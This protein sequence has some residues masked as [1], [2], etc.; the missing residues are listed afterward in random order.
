MLTYQDIKELVEKTIEQGKGLYMMSRDDIFIYLANLVAVEEQIAEFLRNI[1]TEINKV[2][3]D[4][5]RQNP[6]I[7]V[8]GLDRLTKKATAELVIN[9][10]WASRQ[11]TIVRDIRITTLAAQ[12]TAE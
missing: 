1:E 4:L 10:N 7:S 2:C 8:A 9:K 5:E 3:E 6:S 12:R 11:M